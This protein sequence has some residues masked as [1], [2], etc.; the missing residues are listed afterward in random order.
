MLLLGFKGVGRVLVADF[1]ILADFSHYFRQKH[2]YRK[3]SIK[4]THSN[5][6][7]YPYLDAKNEPLIYQRVL[8]FLE[9][10][11]NAHIKNVE[12]NPIF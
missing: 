5:K 1:I 9:P 7:P 2:L 12:K 3:N 10:L 11:I 8:E 6:R 4:C